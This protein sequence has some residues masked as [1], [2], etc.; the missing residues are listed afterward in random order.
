MPVD[1]LDQRKKRLFKFYSNNK[2]LP[3]YSEMLGLFQVK[4]KNAVAKI[5]QKFIELGLVE[6][7]SSGRLI[8]VKLAEPLK[9]L[10]DVQA[11][12]PSAAEEELVDTLSL[13]DYLIKNREASFLLR[14]SGE[15]MIEAG[16]QP[17]DLVILERGRDPRNGDVV[18]A[19]VDHQWTIKYYVKRGSQIFLKPANKNYPIISP[20]EELKIAGV[21]TAVI[22]KYH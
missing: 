6:K 10:G 15:S 13:D 18:V 16:I 8:P 11:G 12:F 14:V 5:I 19:E 1:K 9:V 20:K 2:R 4:S 3:S 21:V 22:R 7:D 17:G